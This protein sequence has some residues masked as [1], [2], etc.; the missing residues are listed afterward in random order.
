LA[1]CWHIIASRAKSALRSLGCDELD[2]IAGR[3]FEDADA[4]DRLR[5]LAESVDTRYLRMA[6]DAGRN[7]P[8]VSKEFAIARALSALVF[9]TQGKR[10]SEVIE[11]AFEL[12]V[13]AADLPFRCKLNIVSDPAQVAGLALLPKNDRSLHWEQFRPVDWDYEQQDVT[14]FEQIL[15]ARYIITTE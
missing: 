10:L 7:T 14:A 5:I 8:R 15:F 9:L 6:E 13:V 3:L 12:C 1:D 2:Q 4:N 11:G